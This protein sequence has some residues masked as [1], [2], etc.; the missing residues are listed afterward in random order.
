[1]K[2]RALSLANRRWPLHDTLCGLS[3][4]A[5]VSVPCSPAQQH[6]HS[7][8][9]DAHCKNTP[10]AFL[11]AVQVAL[12]RRELQKPNDDG[13]NSATAVDMWRAQLSLGQTLHACG[14]RAWDLRDRDQARAIGQGGRVPLVFSP[15]CA[16]VMFSGR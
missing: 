5:S 14:V 12:V 16:V 13:D 2:R 3:G 6:P 15:A 11:V 9:V 1:M 8:R 10:A 4:V 7:F